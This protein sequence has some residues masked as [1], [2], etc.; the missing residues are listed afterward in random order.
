MTRLFSPF[1]LGFFFSSTFILLGILA[2]LSSLLFK[3]NRISL[4]IGRVLLFLENFYLSLKPNS[5]SKGIVSFILSI[6]IFIFF[7]NI[8]SIFPFVFPLRS[9]I[10]LVLFISLTIWCSFI[11]FNNSWNVKGFLSHLV[12]R[13]APFGLAPFLFLI[14]LVRRVIRPITLTVR[15]CANI[16]A[17]HL[18]IILLSSLVFIVPFSFILYIGLNLVELAVGLI[19]SYIFCTMACLYFSEVN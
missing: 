10:R 8:Y 4:F 5:F 19:Q 13:G 14:E 7:L 12:P 2:L 11:F 16:L 6:F 3:I 17:G 1:D 18:L 9:Q 15:L